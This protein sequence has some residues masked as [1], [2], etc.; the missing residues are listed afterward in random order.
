MINLGLIL[1]DFEKAFD[2][3]YLGINVLITEMN[4]DL[5]I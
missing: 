4:Y 3:Q 1:I 2:S 5:K